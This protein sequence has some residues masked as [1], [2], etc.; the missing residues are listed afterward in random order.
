M[1]RTKMWVIDDTKF[2]N[3]G[4]IE[5]KL[6]F[7]IR[8]GVLAPNILNTQ[9]WKF[10][11]KKNKIVVYPDI[12][13][14][15]KHLDPEGRQLWI[16]L[17]SAIEN[18]IIAGEHFGLVGKEKVS[19]KKI[20]IHFKTDRKRIN[21][22]FHFITK[23]VTNKRKAKRIL[24]DNGETTKLKKLP[25]EKHTNAF[26]LEKESD[27]KQFIKMVDSGDD[28]IYSNEKIKNE[29]I[30][31]SRFNR[32]NMYKTNDGIPYR[33]M[34]IPSVSTRVGKIFMSF[35]LSPKYIKKSDEQKIMN[36]SG[37]IIITS[38]KDCNKCWIKT[39]RTL[40]RILL[41]LTS[42]GMSYSFLNQPCQV[43][44]LR[45]RLKKITKDWPQIII[46]VGYAKTAAHTQRKIL[47]EVLK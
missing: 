8:Y 19:S 40:E 11:I 4:S 38:K 39:G 36:S 10:E 5:E 41:E 29:I 18:I 16:S 2:P 24:F 22:L 6:L 26:L 33:T 47:E 3:K 44:R 34:G 1:A 31:W 23:R 7:L 9:P 45:T 32:Y 37:V 30:F 12:S 20:S 25:F 43:K 27:M 46:R 21:K 35:F 28:I 17:G 13:K 42:F 15:L 14:K